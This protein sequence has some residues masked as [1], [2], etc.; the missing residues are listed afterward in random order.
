MTVNAYIH[1]PFCKGNKCH[2]CS[3]VS[4]PDLGL[5]SN[6]IEALISQI[7]AEYKNE[8][9][10]TLYFGGGTPS[11]LEL[12]ELSSVLNLFNFD[13]GAEIT[14][15][16]NPEN[17]S[18]NYLKGLLDLNFNRV[19]IGAQTFN[20]E[21][22][23]LIGRKHNSS[24]IIE[25]VENV[26]KAGFKNTS[27]D[28]IYGLPSQNLALFESDLNNVVKMG[29]QHVSLYGLK[30]EKG[31]YFDE[32]C[33]ENLPDSDLQADMY[34]RAIDILNKNEYNQYEISNFSLSGFESQHNLN[35]WNNNSYYGFGCAASGY[36]DAVRHTNE[37]NLYSYITN[38]L[39]KLTEQNL[40]ECEILEEEIF[41]GLRKTSGI[42]ISEIN[43]KFGIDFYHNYSKIIDKY[44]EYFVK[45]DEYCALNTSGILISN[46]ILSEF[47]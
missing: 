24:Q 37:D 46:L 39:K 1:I 13:S 30:I 21:I 36:V 19:S 42:N 6:Y 14:I 44:S 43:N 7:K 16:V 47:I 26:Q 8:K 25:A 15:E 31:C 41:L 9:L 10:K 5:K 33:L 3:F 20:N 35:Y 2:Y 27:L 22:L 34:L 11:L 45:T 38:P 12:T 32:N 40:T 28:L 29:V 18:L 17:L 23:S 4:F